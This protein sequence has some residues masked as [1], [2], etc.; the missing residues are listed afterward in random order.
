RVQ[1]NGALPLPAEK[2]KPAGN[3]AVTGTSK[4]DYDERILARNKLQQVERTI[5]S[6]QRLDFARQLGEEE[7]Q[8]SLRP[9]ARRL[10]IL[11]HKQ[12][13]VPFC[14]SGPLTWGEIELIRTD[15]FTPALLGLLPSQAVRPGDTWTAAAEAVQE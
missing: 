14:P 15:V 5:R 2:G 3:L 7:Q 1:I 9:E 13:E 8:S 4:V 11:R 6:Y 10:V 12:Y